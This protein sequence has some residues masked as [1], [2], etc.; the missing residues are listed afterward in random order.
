MVLFTPFWHV[1]C[2]TGASEE[3][4]IESYQKRYMRN[5]YNFSESRAS[6]VYDYSLKQLTTLPKN[7]VT[8]ELIQAATKE[9]IS[10]NELLVMLR[11]GMN[12]LVRQLPEYDVVCT[13]YGVWDTAAQLIAEIGNV[14]RFRVAAL[15]RASSA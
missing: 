11:Q 5:G 4:F 15:L 9:L 13:I 1:K 14:L 8:K 10:T 2:V 7:D 12:R 3:T 6:N